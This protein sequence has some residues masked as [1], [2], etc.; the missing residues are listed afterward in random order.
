MLI[1]LVLLMFNK[2][3]LSISLSA[4]LMMSAQA[5]TQEKMVLCSEVAP[6]NNGFDDIDVCQLRS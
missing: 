2:L 1:F 5:D 4:F 3:F 6:C